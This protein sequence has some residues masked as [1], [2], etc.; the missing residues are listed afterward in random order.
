MLINV[1]LI[2]SFHHIIDIGYTEK[3]INQH[4]NNTKFKRFPLG[5]SLLMHKSTE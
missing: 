1:L 4:L 2:Y 3:L 5:N